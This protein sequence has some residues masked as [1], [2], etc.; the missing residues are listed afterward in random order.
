M[1]GHLNVRPAVL[2]DPTS[3][4][5][6]FGLKG[7]IKQP[8]QFNISRPEACYLHLQN[9]PLDPDPNQVNPVLKTLSTH[10]NS[11]LHLLVQRLFII[12]SGNSL[13]SRHIGSFIMIN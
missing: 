5:S 12:L 8:K 10:Y 9:M 3:L 7:L 11:P 2:P 6:W 13:L 1:H 4:P